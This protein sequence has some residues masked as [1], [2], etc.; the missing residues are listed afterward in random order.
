MIYFFMKDKDPHEY[1]DMLGLVY[2]YRSPRR[3]MTLVS[4]AA[5]FAPFAALNGFEEGMEETARYTDERI[6]LAEDRILEINDALMKIL[7][8][9][10]EKPKVSV[11]YFRADE[12]KSGGAYITHEARLVKFDEE[13]DMLIFEDGKRVA[14]E[15]IFEIEMKL[16]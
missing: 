10:R 12:L 5:Q 6:V 1:D 8:V 13:K 4:R 7:A 9:I 16:S 2:P 15:D 14:V 11:V 3:Q